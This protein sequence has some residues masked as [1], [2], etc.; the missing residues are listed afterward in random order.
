MPLSHHRLGYD[1]RFLLG[2]TQKHSELI[3]MQVKVV[4]HATCLGFWVWSTY[5]S[6]GGM[7][8]E[9]RTKKRRDITSLVATASWYLPEVDIQVL[10][11]WVMKSINGT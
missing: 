2:F 3:S 6:S 5:F 9:I 7:P 1:R 4:H 10:P 11:R 8:Q